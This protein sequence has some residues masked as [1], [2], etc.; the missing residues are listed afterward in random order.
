MLGQKELRPRPLNPFSPATTRV[1]FAVPRATRN[2]RCARQR[3]LDLCSLGY[4]VQR[5]SA[6]HRAVYARD[7]SSRA[8]GRASLPSPSEPQQLVAP[9]GCSVPPLAAGVSAPPLRSRSRVSSSLCCSDTAAVI[10]WSRALTARTFSQARS[11]CG[12]ASLCSEQPRR[13]CRAYCQ[14]LWLMINSCSS[15]A[16]A[17]LVALRSGPAAI[18]R[19]LRFS[20]DNAARSARFPRHC[21]G[22]WTRVCSLRQQVDCGRAL[23]R[24]SCACMAL[25]RLFFGPFPAPEPCPGPRRCPGSS[26]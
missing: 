11:L 20:L 24:G 9:C 16:C 5:S 7:I 17:S 14:C 26:P 4:L 3:I 19:W 25:F 18:I 13:R 10:C 2:R 23:S 22:L 6:S 1:A 8:Q 15:R 21:L 12:S